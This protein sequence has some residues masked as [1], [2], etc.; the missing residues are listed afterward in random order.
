M[1]VRGGSGSGDYAAKFYCGDDLA[2][3]IRRK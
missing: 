1:Q 3:W 2:A